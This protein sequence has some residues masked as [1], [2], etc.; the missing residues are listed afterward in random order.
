MRFYKGVISRRSNDEIEFLDNECA[1]INS[2]TKEEAISELI[3]EKKL[4]EKKKAIENYIKSV[5]AREF[6]E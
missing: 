6:D 3:K 1:K 4:L 2:L 5:N